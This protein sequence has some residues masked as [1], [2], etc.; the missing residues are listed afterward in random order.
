[1]N[2]AK[3]K[4]VECKFGS[5]A[6]K[7]YTENKEARKY[8]NYLMGNVVC[9]ESED[10]LKSYEKS[11]TKTVMVYQNK[12]ARQTKRE[13]YATPYIGRESLRI[14]LKSINEKLGEIEKITEISLNKKS[15]FEAL[16]RK[17]KRQQLFSHQPN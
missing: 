3:I 13:V 2:H 16:R 1:M 17:D 8:V 11:I 7:V 5:L 6:E 15:N 10:D 12:A 9:V 14:R 4:D